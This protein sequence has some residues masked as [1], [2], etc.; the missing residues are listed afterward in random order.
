MIVSSGRLA[1]RGNVLLP[2]APIPFQGFKQEQ[3]NGI[4]ESVVDIREKG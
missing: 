1:D 2:I 3:G 4:K